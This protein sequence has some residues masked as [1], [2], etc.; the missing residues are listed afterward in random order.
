MNEE[1]E[2]EENEEK[3]EE[4]DPLE[5]FEEAT[6]PINQWNAITRFLQWAEEKDIYLMKDGEQIGEDI[7]AEYFNIDLEALAYL[8]KDLMEELSVLQA[9]ANK[10]SKKLQKLENIRL[11]YIKF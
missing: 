1:E 5:H 4:E 6:K 7:L 3:E 2:E 10:I 9:Q 8:R 11:N